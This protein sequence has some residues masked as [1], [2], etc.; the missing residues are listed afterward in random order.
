MKLSVWSIKNHWSAAVRGVRQDPLAFA[1]IHNTFEIVYRALKIV[2]CVL[3]VNIHIGLEWQYL[4][5]IYGI[6]MH[7]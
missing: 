3:F 4:L 2:T 1:S 6:H 5:L 7:W